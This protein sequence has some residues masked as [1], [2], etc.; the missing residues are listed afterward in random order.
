MDEEAIG[1]LVLDSAYK[2]H[3]TLGPGLLESAY[4]SCMAHEL[5]KQVSVARQLILP[6]EYDGI[7]LDAG[8]RVD[9][10]VADKIIVELKAVE[11]INDVHFAQ[12]L[13]YLKLSGCRLGYLLNFNVRSM[14][15][16]IKRVVNNT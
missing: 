7:R 11:R 8:Y 12:V 5:S 16:G 2:V 15:H 3:T 9:L 14:K 1:K 6:I 10:L 4:E 13:S